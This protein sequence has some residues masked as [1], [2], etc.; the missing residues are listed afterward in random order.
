MDMSL[1][2]RFE[3]EQ[4]RRRLKDQQNHK[5]EREGKKPKLKPLPKAYA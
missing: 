2:K 5:E 4:S 1:W 3:E